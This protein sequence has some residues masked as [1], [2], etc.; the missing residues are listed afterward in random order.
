MHHFVGHRFLKSST[1]ELRSIVGSMPIS[2]RSPAIKRSDSSLFENQLLVEAVRYDS[3]SVTS[4]NKVGSGVS[5]AH[6]LQRA[7]TVCTQ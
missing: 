1:K 2:A 5:E 4:N 3:K 6:G 7:P